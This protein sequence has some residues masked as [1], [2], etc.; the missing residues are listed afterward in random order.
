MAEFFALYKQCEKTGHKF[1]QKNTEDGSILF[2]EDESSAAV[3][4]K[5]YNT[6][7]IKVN[8]TTALLGD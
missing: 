6:E 8:V 4:S 5:R 3:A 2:Y 1:F 7:Y